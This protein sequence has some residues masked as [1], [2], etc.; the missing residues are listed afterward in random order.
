M[1]R[2]CYAEAAQELQYRAETPRLRFLILKLVSLPPDFPNT[3]EGQC[4]GTLVNVLRPLKGNF[5]VPSDKEAEQRA[6]KEVTSHGCLH[7]CGCCWFTSWP[8]PWSLGTKEEALETLSFRANRDHLS[9]SPAS[10]GCNREH[11]CVSNPAGA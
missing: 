8:S 1:D 10:K 5:S 6:D 2:I 11:P 7:V 3:Q 9:H 4:G